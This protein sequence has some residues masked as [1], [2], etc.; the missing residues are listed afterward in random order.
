MWQYV[1]FAYLAFWVIILV[2]GGVASMVFDAPPVVMTGI[3]ILGSWSPTIVLLL[4]FKK[5]KPGMTIGEFYKKALQARLNI[6]MLIAIPV[7]IFG[8]FLVSIWLSSIIE[9]T[10]FTTQLAIPS[11][12]GFTNS[13]DGLSRTKRR[14]IGL[15]RL[16]ASRAGRALWVHQRKS[17]SGVGLGFLARAAVVCCFRLRWFTGNDLYRCQYRRADGLDADHGCLHEAV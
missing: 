12:L 13:A 5:L 11:A 2:L 3:T 6:S 17:H 9:G 15:A 4:M 16:L 8:I 10:L 14:R 1:I 7:I